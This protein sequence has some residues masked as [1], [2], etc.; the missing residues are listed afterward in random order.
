MLYL[1]WGVGEK[2]IDLHPKQATELNVLIY[3]R[4]SKNIVIASEF[5]Y[6][7]PRAKIVNIREFSCYIQFFADDYKSRKF[8]FMIIPDSETNRIVLKRVKKIKLEKK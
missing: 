1:N 8:Y 7:Q 3:L 6:T 5:G 4:K 2:A